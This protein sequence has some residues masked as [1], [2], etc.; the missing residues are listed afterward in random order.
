VAG[1]YYLIAMADADGLVAE[2]KEN[3]N[4]RY[5]SLTIGP[6]LTVSQLTGP[7]S[8]AVGATIIVNESTRNLGSPTVASTT[9][10]Y[11]S[12]DATLG[13]DDTLLASRAVP[14][15]GVGETS[16]AAVALT[17]PGTIAPGTYYVIAQ[18]DA[19]GTIAELNEANN[20]KTRTISI[21]P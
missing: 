19:D 10:F 18:S 3:N 20:L 1:T 7:T 17:I 4:T 13:A 6:D 5:K 9:R 21:T 15:L 12:T 14:P 8:A 16:A 2:A 11:L